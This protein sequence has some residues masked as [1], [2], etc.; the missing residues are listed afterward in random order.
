MWVPGHCGI[1]GNEIVAIPW[2]RWLHPKT[3]IGTSAKLVAKLRTPAWASQIYVSTCATAMITFECQVSKWPEG[4]ILQSHLYPTTE[5]RLATC[6]RRYSQSAT[7]FRLRMG[8]CKLHFH[9]FQ[10]G[11]HGLCDVCEIPEIVSHF[12]LICPKY[13]A[14][15]EIL[16]ASLRSMGVNIPDILGHSD[17]S[18]LV[19]LFIDETHRTILSIDETEVRRGAKRPVMSK[20]QFFRLY[21]ALVNND[22]TIFQSNFKKHDFPKNVHC[23]F[24]QLL[25]FFTSWRL[26]LDQ[27]FQKASFQLS[28]FRNGSAQHNQSINC[29]LCVVENTSCFNKKNARIG[30]MTERSTNQLNLKCNVKKDINKHD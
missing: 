12:L 24:W 5:R 25:S 28:H 9:L 13:H 29:I 27:M 6:P 16:L 11:L 20:R 2:P 18:R 4:N 3:D 15:R 8:H 10:L 14:Q 21:S 22:F 23:R 17:A 26:S 1:P 19:Q 30:E 7:L